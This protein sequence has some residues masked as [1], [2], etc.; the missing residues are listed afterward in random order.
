MHATNKTKSGRKPAGRRRGVWAVALVLALLLPSLLSLAVTGADDPQIKDGAV[1]RDG[2]HTLTNIA[3][4]Q[5]I[6]ATNSYH[7][8]EGFFDEAFLVDGQYDTY[9]AGN[10]KLGWNTNTVGGMVNE[11]DPVDI[12]VTL[13]SV[14]TVEQIVLKPM[15]WGNGDSFPRDYELQ[16]STDG[17]T[18]TTLASDKDVNAHAESN[19]SVKPLVY[20]IE[21]TDIAYF[22]IHITRHSAVVDP[23]G[24]YTSALGELELYGY[25]TDTAEQ[26]E[27]M[28]NKYALSMNPGEYDELYL[29]RG[30]KKSTHT[31]TYAS[32]DKKVVTVD[33]NGKVTSVGVGTATLTLTDKDT[34]KSYEVPVTVD[35]AKV[36]DHFQIVAFIPYFYAG[37]VNKKT[38]DNLKA[39]GITN[40]EMN[41]ALSP[42]AITYENNLK[43]IKLA[44]ERGLD[45]TVSEVSFN[46]GSWPTKSDEEILAFVKRYAHLPGVTGYY[47]TDEPA[48]A[49]PYA[50]AM[51]LIKSVM[52]NAVAHINFCGAYAPIA[53]SLQ[54]KL[55]KDYGLSM[56]YVMY[57]A[58]VCTGAV[59][60]ESLLYSQLAYNR[61]LGQK[62]GVKTASYVQAMNWNNNHRPNENEVRYQ[63]YAYLASGVKQISYFCWQTPQ[64]N[65]YETY[66]PAVIDINGEPTDLFE[67]VSKINAAVQALGPTLMK[68]ETRAVYH[69]GSSFGGG[70]NQLPA[71]YFIRPTDRRQRLCIGNMTETDTDRPYAMVVNR[72][73]KNTATVTFTV[74]DGV[75]EL[76]RVSPV[77]GK[78]E[79]LT[80]DGE[81]VYSISLLA[82]EGALLTTDAD[83]RDTVEDVTDYYYLETAVE[84][85]LAIDLKTYKADGQDAF[86]AA[87]DTAQ[88][89]LSEKTAGSRE[90]NAARD[91]LEKA[92]T[93]L[94]PL[95]AEGVNLALRMPVT[96]DSSY[97]EGTYW[98]S[99]FLTDGQNL[100]LDES[101]NAGWSVNPYDELAS[102]APVNL[103]VD[104][105]SEY[106]VTSVILKPCIYCDGNT[107]P[108]SFDIMLSVDGQDWTTVWQVFDF[109]TPS[110]ADLVYPVDSINARYVRVRIL[111]HS[112]VTDQGTGGYLSQFGELEVYGAELNGTPETQPDETDTDAGLPTDTEPTDTEPTDTE[113]TDTEPADTEQAGIKPVDTEPDGT[114]PTGTEPT[115]TAPEQA[116]A[117]GTAN[118][119]QDSGCASVLPSILGT[120]MCL[121]ATAACV[122][123]REKLKKKGR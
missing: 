51:A 9:T 107:T 35:T 64:A 117:T 116:D 5:S 102:D 17:V 11:Y 20:D 4:G 72:D 62:L 25:E 22:R 41:F 123:F 87:L 90:V 15:M 85:A 76:F 112:D 121:V 14:Y 10:V 67:P 63:V 98:A 94:R 82:G 96:A 66:G 26:G 32:S 79:K 39:G 7:P 19:T 18:F 58:Y 29:M 43:A 13:D 54:N 45:V 83:F 88:T 81:G 46:G 70:Y 37:D 31:V 59:C 6:A 106:T 109:T 36:T 40:V 103:T 44:H 27:I 38:F 89:I 8:A 77:T 108:R 48:D 118:G 80:P 2:Q 60:N 113:T 34:G 74:S 95:A 69:S 122:I 84:A 110:A 61:E 111:E 55:V 65:A 73:L 92:M 49:T 56:D 53:T 52:P 91:A 30:K 42:E 100:P 23:S 47:V 97:E 99:A 1:S 101:P 21:P 24:P 71:G 86:R 120:L 104:L 33:G 115:G 105:K 57:D 93:A 12:T 114:E 78:L 16:G 75:R 68:L 28:V 119:T 50:R 3:L